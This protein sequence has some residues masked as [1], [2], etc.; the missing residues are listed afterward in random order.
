MAYLSV[1]SKTVSK[2]IK[3]SR[4]FVCA[5]VSLQ[6]C[7]TDLSHFSRIS[8]EEIDEYFLLADNFEEPLED[9]LPH[10][11]LEVD[12]DARVPTY[13]GVQVKEEN[14]G[15][16]IEYETY[17]P[18]PIIRDENAFYAEELQREHEQHYFP[19]REFI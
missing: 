11:A 16:H 2:F 9:E 1:H 6:N 17:N 4:D 5:L 7:R 10:P 12:E 19:R 13:R 15:T 8:V 3:Q 14:G 18:P